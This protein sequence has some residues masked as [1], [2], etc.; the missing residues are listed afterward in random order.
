V[1]ARPARLGRVAVPLAVGLVALAATVRARGVLLDDGAIV[2][3]YVA[4]LVHGG[5]WAF[6]AYDA[7]GAASAAGA[8][9]AR[10]ALTSA[11]HPLLIA[12][13]AT[14]LRDVP[15]AQHV[16]GGLGLAAAGLGAAALLRGCGLTAAGIVAGLLLPL[17]PEL[18]ATWGLETGWFL[19]LLL[20][21]PQLRGTRLWIGVAL[22]TLTRPDGLLL[23]LAAALRCRHQ[24][25]R[26][27][28]RGIAL[29]AGLCL[30]WLAWSTWR[31]G[32]PVPATLGVKRAQG[33]GASGNF[34]YPTG[35]RVR[36]LGLG[37]GHRGVAVLLVLLALAGL[38]VAVRRRLVPLLE[39]TA[40]VGVQ[41]AAYALAPVPAYRWYYVPLLAL[42]MVLALVAAQSALEEAATRVGTRALVA[43][44]LGLVLL[45]VGAAWWSRVPSRPDARERDFAEVAGYLTAQR[46]T[47]VA[48]SEVGVLGAGLPLRTTVTDITGLVTSPPLYLPAE[49]HRFFDD[50]APWV[51][52]HW[53]S[54][55]AA[56]PTATA[57]ARGYDPT[58]RPGTPF[59]SETPF[60]TDPLFRRLY[61]L[62]RRV[63]RPPY[64]AL[65]VFRATA[66]GPAS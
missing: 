23:G 53:F 24:T 8:G 49:R 9:P 3:R 61:V 11:A 44:P 65:L 5:G 39:L 59:S 54:D 30:P 18:Q 2:T 51:V 58:L 32:S 56:D 14:V 4:N 43:A 26:L 6:N 12:L 37:G 47:R 28:L 34:A 17:L 13:A 62:A 50:P 55:R 45:T 7:P 20:F 36:L 19:A 52:L 21:V 41:Q 1:R 15:L 38:A 46:A 25:R 27:P 22:A 31:F 66:P 63:E 48:S 29:A 16:V 35:W 64:A 40:V 57:V 60:L 33:L 42:V 10:N